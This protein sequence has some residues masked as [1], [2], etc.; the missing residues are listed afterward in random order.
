MTTVPEDVK[1]QSFS[2]E[3]TLQLV[4]MVS[5]RVQGK[6]RKE[7][8]RFPWLTCDRLSHLRLCLQLLEWAACIADELQIEPSPLMQPL[9]ALY[10]RDHPEPPPFMPVDQIEANVTYPP[11]TSL[12]KQLN[13]DFPPRVFA[14]F[15]TQ[16]GKWGGRNHDGTHGLAVFTAE[17]SARAFNNFLPVAEVEI[18]NLSFDEA[19]EVAKHRPLPIICLLL[20]DDLDNPKV[21]YVR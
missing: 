19:R 3:A 2:D 6:F 4:W 20:C 5:F 18:V 17:Q 12:E 14:L 1:Y 7:T 10:R 11:A 9:W 13:C 16:T 21:H 15:H 8:K